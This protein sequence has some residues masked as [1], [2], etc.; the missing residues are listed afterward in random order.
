[1]QKELWDGPAV[2]W[3]LLILFLHGLSH[4]PTQLPYCSSKSSLNTLETLSCLNFLFIK[5]LWIF[6]TFIFCT[7]KFFIRHFSSKFLVLA[8]PNTVSSAHQCLWDFPNYLHFKV[9]GN[10]VPF[11]SLTHTCSSNFYHRVCLSQVKLLFTSRFQLHLNKHIQF[12]L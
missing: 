3:D 4:L 1:M 2:G 12:L 9:H 8:L 7:S 11:H 6:H 5:V 10:Y